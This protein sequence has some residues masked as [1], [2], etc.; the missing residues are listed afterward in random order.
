MQLFLLLLLLLFHLF[1]FLNLLY[2]YFEVFVTSQRHLETFTVYV[3][4]FNIL[5]SKSGHGYCIKNGNIQ[6][7]L[8]HYLKGELVLFP[9]WDILRCFRLHLLWNV[10]RLLIFFNFYY[11]NVSSL[12]WKFFYYF[13]LCLTI[14][15]L[16]TLF[17]NKKIDHFYIYLLR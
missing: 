11:Y 3:F 4:K 7:I 10:K 1:L 2:I 13:K 9:N 6:L 5:Q 17:F 8:R 16:N 14:V 15:K 12:F